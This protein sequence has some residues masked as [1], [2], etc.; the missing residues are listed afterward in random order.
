MRLP[1]HIESLQDEIQ[2]VRRAQVA[3]RPQRGRQGDGKKN[4]VHTGPEN[5]SGMGGVAALLACVLIVPSSCKPIE[6]VSSKEP[7]A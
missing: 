5:S 6:S 3:P 7:R 2:E 1:P 4:T